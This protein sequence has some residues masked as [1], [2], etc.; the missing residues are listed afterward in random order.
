MRPEFWE[1]SAEL[2]ADDLRN[3]LLVVCADVPVDVIEGW[4]EHERML[5][6]DWAAREHLAAS[7]NPVKR[8]P[9][10]SFLSQAGPGRVA[11]LEQL[12]DAILATFTTSDAGYRARVGQVQI[13]KWEAILLGGGQ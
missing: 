13:K 1:P 7:D 5:A 8:R 10:P 3:V 9:R 6:Y 11:E 12:A 2:S 4:T